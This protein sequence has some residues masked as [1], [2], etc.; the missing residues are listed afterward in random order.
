MYMYVYIYI[1]IHMYIHM[2]VLSYL[3][4]RHV[5]PQGTLLPNAKV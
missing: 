4:C 3:T 5:G 2:C 1:Y